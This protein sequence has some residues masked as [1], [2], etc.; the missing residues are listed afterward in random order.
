MHSLQMPIYSSKFSKRDFTRHQL[1][2][3]LII[4]THERKGYECFVE[5]LATSKVVKWLKLKKIPH[6]TTLQKFAQ[7]LAIK[8][9]EQILMESAK[10]T[11]K[12]MPLLMLQD[13]L[14]EIP[15]DIM[16]KG[17]VS[18]LRRE[19]SSSSAL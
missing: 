16:R 17:W 10:V 12:C 13:F 5:W 7:R 9:L 2:T 3:L 19:T 4:K 8:N 15:V 1:L 11:K 18:R 6:F 14:C